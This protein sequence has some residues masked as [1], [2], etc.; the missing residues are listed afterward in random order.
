MTETAIP[1]LVQVMK[2]QMTPEQFAQELATTPVSA[3][4]EVAVP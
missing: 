4:A 1:N 2:G 3:M